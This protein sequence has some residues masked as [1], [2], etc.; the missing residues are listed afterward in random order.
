[1]M[2]A[3]GQVTLLVVGAT[4]VGPNWVRSV[5]VLLGGSAQVE[6]QGAIK[7]VKYSAAWLASRALLASWSAE[8]LHEERL[9]RPGTMMEGA[10]F[11]VFEGPG[12][13]VYKSVDLL[14]YYV[15]HLSW[16]E[17][18]LAGAAKDVGA[19]R[20]HVQRVAR[21]S[22]RRGLAEETK[23]VSSGGRQRPAA[24]RVAAVMPFYAAGAGQGPS[25]VEMRAGYLNATLTSIRL[26]LTDRV[27]VAVENA[28]DRETA[29][30]FGPFFDELY[31][32]GLVS[33]NKL[34]VAA[35]IATHRLLAGLPW[36]ASSLAPTASPGNPSKWTDVDYVYYTESDQILRLRNPAELLALV[37]RSRGVIVPRR[38]VPVPLPE[39][40]GPAAAEDDP[41][42]NALL[43]TDEL[44]NNM[45]LGVAEV[46]S[47][48][49]SCCFPGTEATACRQVDLRVSRRD[50]SF[51]TPPPGSRRLRKDRRPPPPPTRF[52]LRSSPCRRQLSQA[53]LPLLHPP[54]RGRL[55]SPRLSTTT[56]STMM[57]DLP[58]APQPTHLFLQWQ[59]TK[60]SES[61][62]AVVPDSAWKRTASL[63]RHRWQ[64]T[65]RDRWSVGSSTTS[66]L[67]V[68]RRVDT[69]LRIRFS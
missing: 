10:S 41:A 60:M 58:S 40:F 8:F 69:S 62:A 23:R 24:A 15:E 30:Q 51:A 19:T 27:V 26:S 59:H 43:E 44:R 67:M 1:M 28:Q 66:G 12:T 18:L 2:A 4:E 21:A 61:E 46:S 63:R 25:A 45:A 53:P 29:R 57:D 56:S 33:P 32:P 49:C 52:R 42:R 65:S 20:H 37:D 22:F 54:L 13:K 39:D 17:R 50:A 31:L 64:V 6:C 47:A 48:C 38:V 16:Y 11:I 9:R 34:G 5:V 3:V 55:R 36:N 14:D 35:L 7:Q 68:S